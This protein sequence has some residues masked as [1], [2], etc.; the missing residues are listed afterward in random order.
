[1]TRA[2]F[3]LF[4][5]LTTAFLLFYKNAVDLYDVRVTRIDAPPAIARALAGVKIVYMSDIHV[6]AI[7]SRERFVLD[8]IERERPDY[9]LIGGDLKP[10]VGSAEPSLEFFRR[11]KAKRGAYAVLGDAEYRLGT[12]NCVYCHAPGRWDVRDDLPVRVLR[13]QVVVLDGADGRPAVDLWAGDVIANPDLAWA[14]KGARPVLAMAHWPETFPYYAAAGADWM[15]SGDTHGGQVHV[16][17]FVYRLHV[18]EA[19]AR[20]MY[21]AFR[22]GASSMWVTAGLGWTG[23]PLRLGVRPEVVIVDIPGGK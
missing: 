8:L 14:K 11:V 16:P 20:Y 1:M 9:V 22:E 19:Q 21:G 17:N 5:A 13:D 12:Q 23:A 6:R 18:G 7:G 4:A 3:A 2:R 10:Y 15:L